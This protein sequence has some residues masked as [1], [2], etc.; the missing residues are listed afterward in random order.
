MS[1]PITAVGPLKVLTNPILMESAA[2]AEFASARDVTPASQNAALVLIFPPRLLLMAPVHRAAPFGERSAPAQA[3]LVE[4]PFF[5]REM[6]GQR[7]APTARSPLE[8][9]AHCMGKCT[10]IRRSRGW[11]EL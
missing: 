1:L 4:M 9:L 6:A 5:V 10:I 2:T 7:Q 11:Q 3:S 8:P